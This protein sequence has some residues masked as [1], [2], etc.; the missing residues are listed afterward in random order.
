MKPIEAMEA[1][2]YGFGAQLG[3]DNFDF[4]LEGVP[5]LVATREEAKRQADSHGSSDTENYD[6]AE[7]KRSTA[8]LGVTAFGV[9]ERAEPVGARQSRVEIE[10]LLKRSGLEDQMKTTGVWRGWDSGERGRLP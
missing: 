10:D 8:V 2:H 3:T 4:V 9:S 1:N 6:L 7:L 5:T